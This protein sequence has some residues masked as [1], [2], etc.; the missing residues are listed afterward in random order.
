[1]KIAFLF[2]GQGSQTSGMGKDLY[3]AFPE[4]RQIYDKVEKITGIDVKKITFDEKENAKINQTSYTQ[5]CILTMSLAILELLKKENIKAEESAGL[6]LGEYAALIYSNK[7]SFEDGAKAIKIRGK[8]MEEQAPIGDWKMVAI[9]GLDESGV[10]KA[11]KK[12]TSGFVDMANFNCNT[13]IV[14]SGEKEAVIEASNYAKE[15]GARKI[16]ALKTSEPFHTKLLKDA[17]IKLKDELKKINFK[18][19]KTEVIRN[20]DGKKYSDQDDMPEIL[21]R[22]II[23][24]V[25]FAESIKTMLDDGVDTFIEIGP[26]KSLTSFVKRTDS[27][28]RTF[29]INN[30]KSF[31]ETVESIKKLELS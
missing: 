21:S 16:V 8:I 17:S 14:I 20:I 29:N 24:P 23:S 3:D 11:C 4:Y 26:G 2:P 6:S 13:Q 12:V 27:N 10:R 7:L 19:F 1:M 22:H 18:S 30:K 31:E 15:L 9:I 28:V 25:R 5:I